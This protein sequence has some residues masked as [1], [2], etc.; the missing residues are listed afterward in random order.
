MGQGAGGGDTRLR[1]GLRC[2][3]KF[4]P[5]SGHLCDEG[6]NSRTE[7]RWRPRRLQ[8]RA[9]LVAPGLR[10]W[11]PRWARRSH[12]A[13]SPD[14]FRPGASRLSRLCPPLGEAEL[15][16]GSGL[17]S[18]AG[19]GRSR[20]GDAGTWQ[21]GGSVPG[22]SARCGVRPAALPAR[23]TDGASRGSERARRPEASGCPRGR[24]CS[25]CARWG[26]APRPSAPG[27]RQTD[28]RGAGLWVAQTWRPGEARATLRRVTRNV[29][30]NAWAVLPRAGG[31]L[32][33]KRLPGAGGAAQTPSWGG[34]AG[35]PLWGAEWPGSVCPA[36]GPTAR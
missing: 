35:S 5:D 28:R 13:V 31:R 32:G 22:H 23:R 19:G 2:Y 7:T 18:E 33:Q 12:P 36:A 30:G 11:P 15:R 34:S 17:G 8:P 9:R 14:W 1:M 24:W 10:A 25:A 16:A 21:A 27:Q 3:S 4:E 20:A 26:S 29:P 6:G